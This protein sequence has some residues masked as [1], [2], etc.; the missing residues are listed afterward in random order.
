MNTSG[1]VAAAQGRMHE[2]G[3]RKEAAG[4]FYMCTPPTHTYTHTAGNSWYH[5]GHAL[6]GKLIPGEGG[7]GTGSRS[8]SS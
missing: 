6:L 1:G 7:R 5:P 4:K 2:Q 8:V 3:F